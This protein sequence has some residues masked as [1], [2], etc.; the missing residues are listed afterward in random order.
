MRRFI[1][2]LTIAFFVFSGCMTVGSLDMEH[3]GTPADSVLVYGTFLIPYDK[4]ETKYAN[5]IEF[6]FSQLNPEKRP[7]HFTPVR[8]RWSY[9]IQPQEPGAYLKLTYYEYSFVDTFITF[10]G[11]QVPTAIDFQVPTTPGLYYRGSYILKKGK[12]VLHAPT[13]KGEL[14]SLQDIL[15]IYV[16]TEWEQLILARIKELTDAKN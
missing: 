16:N 4:T 10:V 15:P 8:R 13:V 9:T 6:R 12:E 1:I 14:E 7:G 11:I 5:N 3:L 2:L